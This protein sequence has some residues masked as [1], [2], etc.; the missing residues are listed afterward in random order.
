MRARQYDGE[1]LR[2]FFADYAV[3]GQRSVRARRLFELVFRRLLREEQ[4]VALAP[5]C[6]RVLFAHLGAVARAQFAHVPKL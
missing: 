6:V 3:H 1:G 2:R 5:E 4:E